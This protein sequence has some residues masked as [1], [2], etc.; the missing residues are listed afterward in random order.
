MILPVGRN[1]VWDFFSKPSNLSKLTPGEMNLKVSKDNDREVYEGMEL[2][3]EVSPI[4]GIHMKWISRITKVKKGEYFIDEQLKGPFAFWRHE[5]RFN[6]VDGGTEVVDIL[7]YKMPMGKLGKLAYPLLVKG[8][9]EDLFVYR[10]Q[11][12]QEIFGV[13]ESH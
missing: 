9:I 2:Q 3:F 10:K 13:A 11:E 5:H 7:T 4:M 12:L 6:A 8:K 1:E